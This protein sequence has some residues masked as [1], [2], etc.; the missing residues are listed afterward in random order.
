MENKTN[1][2]LIKQIPLWGWG[3][4]LILSIGFLSSLSIPN[5][6]T[7]N[8]SNSNVVK[9]VNKQTQA[10]VNFTG[11]QF[12]ITNAN[13]FD[14]EE[15]E[16]IINEKY[17]YKTGLMKSGSTYEIGARQFTDGK[18]VRFNPFEIKPAEI[19]IWVKE[20]WSDDWYGELK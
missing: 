17:R 11:T 15:V 18:N 8:N 9:E 14:W 2:S 6:E 4:I 10:K 1:W 19:R 3:L 12:V 16:I 20:P 7:K 13:D 5:R